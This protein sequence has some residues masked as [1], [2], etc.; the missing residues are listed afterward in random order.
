MTKRQR[1][2]H[3]AM[4][5]S[6]YKRAAASPH[7]AL[8]ILR[9]LVIANLS[10]QQRRIYD[11]IVW[12]GLDGTTSADVVNEFQMPPTLVSTYLK[13]LTDYGLLV[14]EQVKDNVGMHYRYHIAP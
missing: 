2:L 5:A 9:S 7:E 6:A 13:E 8:T 1:F 4:I 12:C 3:V 10:A 14:R 11:L